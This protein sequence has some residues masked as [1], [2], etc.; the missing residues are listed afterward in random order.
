M[1]KEISDIKYSDVGSKFY[2]QKIMSENGINVAEFICITVDEYD[3]Q[4][5]KFKNDINLI[6]KNI[7]FDEISSVEN[8]SEKIKSLFFGVR[9]RP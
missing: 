6:I 2:N 1:I 9:H 7:D 5:V 8:G 4:F 3:K